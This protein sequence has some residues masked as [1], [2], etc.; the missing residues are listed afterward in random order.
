ME[1]EQNTKINDKTEWT[2]F[3]ENT[4]NAL[5]TKETLA[6]IKNNNSIFFQKKS[7]AFI[8]NNTISSC[9]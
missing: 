7:I 2:G 8:N 1:A 6:K 4:T 3:V 9:Y 5:P